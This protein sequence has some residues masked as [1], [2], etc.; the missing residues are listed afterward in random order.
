MTVH[1]H[2]CDA[3]PGSAYIKSPG[4]KFT[5]M[6]CLQ[7]MGRVMLLAGLTLLMVTTTS[8]S[9]ARVGPSDG[10]SSSLIPSL[11]VSFGGGGGGGGSGSGGGRTG[12]YGF[13]VGSG[14]GSGW[15]SRDRAGGRGFGGGDGGGVGRALEVEEAV[16]GAVAVETRRV[17]H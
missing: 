4:E 15:G 9:G 6:F 12:G 7:K 8:V 17:A 3:L 10:S 14:D 1:S 2:V 11:K 5:S 13:G 16:A